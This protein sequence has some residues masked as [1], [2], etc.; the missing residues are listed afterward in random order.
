[1][2][3]YLL[4]SADFITTGGQDRA[5][6]ALA[7]HLAQAGYEV[8]LVAHSVDDQLQCYPNVI[9]HR[10]PRPLRSALL[11]ERWLERIGQR[12]A[13]ELRSRGARIIVNG[14]NCTLPDADVN[15]VHYVHA[16]YA[17]RTDG[18]L[19][20]LRYRV[21]HRRYLESERRALR[22][23]RVVIANSHRTAH[24][25]HEHLGIERDRIR[26]IYYGV[27]WEFRPRAS[28]AIG[29]PPKVLFIGGLTDHRK[30]LDVAL[31][32]WEI[33]CADP[34]WDAELHVIGHG[35]QAEA[36]RRRAVEKGIGDRVR[37][38][39]FRNDVPELLRAA[40]ALVSPTRYEP[41]GL[42]VH[43]AI[44]CGI[45]AFVSASAG[46]AE[47]YPSQIRSLLLPDPNDAEDL[48][49]RLRAW[50]T[51]PDRSRAALDQF[52]REL[53][54]RTW[55]DMAVEIEGLIEANPS[56]AEVAAAT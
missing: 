35:A 16:A 11:G 5:N 43:E 42:G 51:E 2:S 12:V 54:D 26:V 4:I 1:M 46:I 3:V 33:L 41:Y 39:G 56:R 34:A 22:S 38:L 50:R 31:L 53:R 52:S 47:R 13:R 14:G 23:A 44:C 30:G 28:T 29:R 17:R 20:Q 45:P 19:R 36:L 37:F 9:V 40:D 10:A 49:A 15:W 8:H 27:G 7:S 32:A 25:L 6:H 48:A 55:D 24:D 18:A 21:A